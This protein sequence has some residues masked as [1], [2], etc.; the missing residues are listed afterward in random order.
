M[1]N[2][3]MRSLVLEF[4]QNIFNE[5][6]KLLREYG[7]DENLYDELDEQCELGIYQWFLTELVPFEMRRYF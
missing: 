3:F 6:A 5:T 2:L 7:K 4:G 1:Q